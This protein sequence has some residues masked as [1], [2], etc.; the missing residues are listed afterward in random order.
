MVFLIIYS[1]LSKTRMKMIQV[2]SATLVNGKYTRE[3][4]KLKKIEKS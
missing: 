3:N 2:K 1:E 4:T